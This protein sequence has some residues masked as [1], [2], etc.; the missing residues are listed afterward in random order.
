M[1]LESPPGRGPATILLPSGVQHGHLVVNEP[2]PAQFALDIEQVHR[3]PGQRLAETLLPYD[4][5]ADL[6]WTSKWWYMWTQ[7]D[8]F[9][10]LYSNNS[11][12]LHNIEV[13]RQKR[14]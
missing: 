10:A 11:K 9:K 2:D 13:M 12:Y 14:R 4:S 8:P 3:F 1:W 5:H 7:V 6:Q